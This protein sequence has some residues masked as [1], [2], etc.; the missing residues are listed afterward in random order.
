MEEEKILNILS[1]IGLDED[2]A[3]S[4]TTL[5][6][7]QILASIEI[8]NL[9]SELCDTF[10]ITIPAKE[11]IPENFNSVNAMAEMVQRLQED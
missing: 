10:D 11:I 2:T 1:E 6:D 7:D 4:S 3:R 5:I 8:I 9:I